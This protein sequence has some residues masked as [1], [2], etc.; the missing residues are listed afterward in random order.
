M[1]E[2]IDATDFSRK[3]ALRSLVQRGSVAYSNGQGADKA[4]TQAWAKFRPLHS[5]RPDARRFTGSPRSA[6][7][8]AWRQ[9]LTQSASTAPLETLCHEGEVECKMQEQPNGALLASSSPIKH[10][11]SV[12]AHNAP[13]L[14]LYTGNVRL[15]QDAN[16]VE[17]PWLQFDRDP[18][19]PSMPRA[20]PSKPVQTILIKAEKP[21]DSKNATAK[22]GKNTS[23]ALASTP[24]T[25]AALKLTYPD[26][27]RTI[28][29]EGGVK[30]YILPSPLQARR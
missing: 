29:Y 30:Y 4:K 8:A 13:V 27:D 16:V 19:L 17:A 14:A 24:I 6:K 3:A 26:A 15:W 1:E 9:L 12:T 7:T 23:N 18:P 10:R 22:A 11:Q 28:H 20:Q 25:I 5:A 21:A 2:S